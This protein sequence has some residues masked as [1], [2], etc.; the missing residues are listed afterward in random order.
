[1]YRVRWATT[2]GRRID[3]I[4]DAQTGVVLRAEGG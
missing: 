3:Y 2:D 1:V 4:V